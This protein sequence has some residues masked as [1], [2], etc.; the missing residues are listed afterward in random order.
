MS[1]PNKLRVIKAAKAL[2]HVVAMIG[3]GVNDTPALEAAD[4]S[5][6]MGIGVDLAKVKGDGRIH[7]AS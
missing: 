1:P 3:D 5:C 6:T 7:P 4:V 2:G